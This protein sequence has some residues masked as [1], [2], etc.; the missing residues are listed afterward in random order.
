MEMMIQTSATALYCKVLIDI[1]R[2]YNRS[3]QYDIPGW[4]Y[5]FASVIMGVIV[6]VI[7]EIADG[8]IMTMQSVALCIL[9]G[10]LAAAQAIGVTELQK[11]S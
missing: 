6:S 11:R 2:Y 7:L 10:I 3:A 1:W 4:F 5:S 8:R 9:N